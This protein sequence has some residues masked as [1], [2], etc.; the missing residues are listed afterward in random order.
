MSP[1]SHLSDSLGA[2]TFEPVSRNIHGP[3]NPVVSPHHAAFDHLNIVSLAGL[4]REYNELSGGNDVNTIAQD[5][6]PQQVVRR[7][8]EI[9][10]STVASH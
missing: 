7:P 9:Q 4:A 10:T 1:E 6:L 8:L 5:H 2:D 3:R